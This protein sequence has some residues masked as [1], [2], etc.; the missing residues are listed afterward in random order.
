MRFSHYILSFSVLDAQPFF[1]TSFSLVFFFQFE[2]NLNLN[3]YK[4][5]QSRYFFDFFPNKSMEKVLEKSCK[6]T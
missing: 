5:I 2:R 1:V 4:I 3:R 6:Q